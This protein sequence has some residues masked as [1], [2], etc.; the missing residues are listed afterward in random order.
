MIREIL[1][2]YIQNQC[3]ENEFEQLVIWLEKN[4][5][6]STD[7]NQSYYLWKSLEPEIRKGEEA[8]FATLLD[9][10]H[11]EITPRQ[12][13]R[14]YHAVVALFKAARWYSRVA[15]ALFIPLLVY[16][17]FF[18]RT[19]SMLDGSSDLTADSLE[20]I[21]SLGSRSIAQLSDGTKVILNAGSKIK[22]P[23]IFNSNTREIVLVGEGYFNVAHDPGKPFI[24]KTSKLNVRALGTEFNVKAYPDENIS[25]TLVNGEVEIEIMLPGKEVEQIAALEPGQSLTYHQNTN[26]ITTSRGDTDLIISWIDG[27]IV[28][29]NAPLNEV[30]R[31]L[32]RIYNVD[33]EVAEDIEDLTYTVA[34]AN[35]PLFLILELMAEITPIRFRTISRSKLPDGTFSKQRIIIEKRE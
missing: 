27:R 8:K 29:D 23:R 35:D 6:K 28:F 12:N 18:T 25:T 32:S 3:S 5:W 11:D 26:T 4:G 16:L 14:R 33:I 31:E 7:L 30:S 1:N 34:F 9:K 15:A 21:S 10:I 20:V 22:Y 2:K 17:F 24:V 19:H 13:V